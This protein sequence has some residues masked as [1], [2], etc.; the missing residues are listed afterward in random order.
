MRKKKENSN[1]QTLISDNGVIS[2]LDLFSHLTII[3]CIAMSIFLIYL[4]VM[5]VAIG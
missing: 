1:V 3:F 4:G 2:K 5:A